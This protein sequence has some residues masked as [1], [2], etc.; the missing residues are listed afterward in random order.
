MCNCLKGAV[1]FPAWRCP[2]AHSN[3]IEMIYWVW[4]EN[5][6]LLNTKLWLVAVIKLMQCLLPI[7]RKQQKVRNYY[8]GCRARVMA[9]R[10]LPGTSMLRHES[11]SLPLLIKRTACDNS[12]LWTELIILRWTKLS[13][14]YQAL[15]GHDYTPHLFYAKQN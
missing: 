10:H 11:K 9:C 13:N 5:T 2:C 7:K 1:F 8:A 3:S 4:G 12:D 15:S 6:N 14:L